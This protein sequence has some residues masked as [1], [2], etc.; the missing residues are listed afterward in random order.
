V[1]TELCKIFPVSSI[2]YEYVKANGSKSFSPVMCGQKI[3]LSWLSKLA[4]TDTRFGYETAQIRN[5]LG[6][7][8]DKQN[9][10]KATPETHAVDGIALAAS[11]FISYESFHSS[12]NHGH[13]WQGSVDITP[14]PF[15][16][17]RRPP[18]SRRQLH[19]MAPAKGGLRRKYGGSTTPFNIRKGDLV[20]YKGMIGYC[21]GYTGNSLSVSDSDWKR[22]G[23]YAASKVQL[24][25]RANRLIVQGEF[26]RRSFSPPR[27]SVVSP[28]YRGM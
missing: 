6:L 20:H 5:Q 9:K 1:V 15:F 8:K 27:F 17:I 13:E 18:I 16:V 23:R 24:V 12:R 28:T 7:V 25:C 2:I 4:P 26:I 11:Q 19:L 14:S 21:S 3:M 22:L 10:G